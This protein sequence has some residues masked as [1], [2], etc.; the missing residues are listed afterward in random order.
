MDRLTFPHRWDE[1]AQ[2]GKTLLVDN[3]NLKPGKPLE[4]RLGFAT[5]SL[6]VWDPKRR[7]YPSGNSYKVELREML[8]SA[9]GVYIQLIRETVADMK[10]IL[11]F[12]E[13]ICYTEDP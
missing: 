5:L 11:C 2:V 12:D 13:D 6:G 1:E 3:P 9:L 8:L 4:L 7:P 10:A